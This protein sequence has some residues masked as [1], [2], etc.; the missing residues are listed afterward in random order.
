MA[1]KKRKLTPICLFHYVKLTYRSV[2]FV[3]ALV[4]YIISRQSG[5]GDLFRGYEDN[6]WIL[7]ES[8]GSSFFLCQKFGFPY[9]VFGTLIL[10]LTGQM[11]GAKI[12]LKKGGDYVKED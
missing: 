12:S 3:V 6:Y 2:L 1:V 10:A 7:G 8:V 5:T 9:R 4:A 11:R